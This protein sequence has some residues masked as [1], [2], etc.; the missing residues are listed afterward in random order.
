[1]SRTGK[2]VDY[3]RKSF[4]NDKVAISLTILI[5]LTLIGIIVVLILPSN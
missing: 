4:M 5:I 1:M 3:F 2:K